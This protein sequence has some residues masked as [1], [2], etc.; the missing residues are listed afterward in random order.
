[1][2][3]LL[4]T[5]A[6]IRHFANLPNIGKAA[7]EI[8]KKGEKKQHILLI[9]VISLME[10]MYLAEKHRISVN[11]SDTIDK[12]NSNSAY[13]IIELSTDILLAAETIEFYELHDRLILATAKYL[14]C[15]VISSDKKFTEI[16]DIEIIW[17]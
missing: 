3:Y 6:I 12:I 14:D 4:D 7:K 15:P 10:I 2:E 5:N 17:E 9:S 1:M 11:L 16:E 13:S 8:I